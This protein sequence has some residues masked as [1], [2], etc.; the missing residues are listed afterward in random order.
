M[1]VWLNILLTL[2]GF[3]IL[4]YFVAKNRGDIDGLGD[5]KKTPEHPIDSLDGPINGQEG[6]ID[7][8]D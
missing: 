4:A 6:S 3:C 7:D 5:L 8:L 2:I 1:P